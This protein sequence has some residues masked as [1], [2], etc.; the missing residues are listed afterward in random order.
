MDKVF[1]KKKFSTYFTYYGVFSLIVSLLI[2]V[3]WSYILNAINEVQAYEKINIFIESYGISN[4]FELNLYDELKEKDSSNSIYEVNVY[5]FS[6]K[7]E[8]LT[9]YYDSFGKSA[10]IVILIEEDLIDMNEYIVDNFLELSDSLLSETIKNKIND[11]DYYEFESKRYALKLYDKDKS[12]SYLNDKITY[13]KEGEQQYTYY[14]LINNNS[15]NLGNY[16]LESKTNNALLT[17]SYLFGE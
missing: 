3:G 11:Y 14:A 13:C 9:S 5:Q 1:T 15:V 7:D 8:K 16:S 17:W 10:D 4:S 12:Y 2:C 6:P